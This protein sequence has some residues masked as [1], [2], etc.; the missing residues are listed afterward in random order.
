M[1][2]YV[3]SGTLNST[4]STQLVMCSVPRCHEAPMLQAASFHKV[5]Q[6]STWNTWTFVT[7]VVIQ[8]ASVQVQLADIPIPTYIPVW[9]MAR[10]SFTDG[11]SR[12]NWNLIRQYHSSLT[13]TSQVNWEVI[14]YLITWSQSWSQ[15]LDS[16]PG[17]K[18]T[19]SNKKVIR[20]G[21]SQMWRYARIACLTPFLFNPFVGGDPLGRSSWFLVGE[22]PD[23]KATIWCNNIPE[24]LNP[25]SR[26]HARHRRQTDG[27]A[28]PLSKRN[29]V[30]HVWLKM[31]YSTGT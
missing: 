26:V 1:T 14:P 9:T 24:K 2:Y 27:F 31:P 21:D 7:I 23:A 12:H 18:V 13:L 17:H 6:S 25:L 8:S 20:R 15:S 5:L 16:Q 4:N 30:N 22:L 19:Y 11:C 29:V 28:M 10:L 3:S